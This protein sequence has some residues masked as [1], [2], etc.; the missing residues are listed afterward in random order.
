[1]NCS[2]P[3]FPLSS[4]MSPESPPIHFLT[5][6]WKRSSSTTITLCT[7]GLLRSRVRSPS[8]VAPPV[9]VDHLPNRGD[10]H[11]D[12]ECVEPLP[13]HE[14]EE[15][16][17]VVPKEDLPY[18]VLRAQLPLQTRPVHVLARIQRVSLQARFAEE[19]LGGA[20]VHEDR[21]AVASVAA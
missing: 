11:E 14:P 15:P 5:A 6:G 8:K 19:V 4:G 17:V 3:N 13:L 2:R 20:R 12:V 18:L 16:L 7:L 10:Q 1:M 9:V 21:A